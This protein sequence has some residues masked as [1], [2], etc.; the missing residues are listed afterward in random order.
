MSFLLD[1]PSLVVL[2]YLIGRFGRSR[3]SRARLAVVVV[4]VFLIVSGLLYL[5]VIP[6]WLGGWIDGSDWMLNSGLPTAVER[7]PGIDVLAVI[8]FA[9]YPLWMKLGLDVARW[10]DDGRST[11]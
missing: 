3:T 5:D 7:G 6:W 4:A 11:A 8:L 9:S 1:P 2:G 10:T